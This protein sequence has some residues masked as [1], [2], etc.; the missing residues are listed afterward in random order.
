MSTYGTEF[1]H[2]DDD[3]DELYIN[4][5]CNEM[6][7]MM[8]YMGRKGI[9][10]YRDDVARL[11]AY[12]GDVLATI[13]ERP[14]PPAPSIVFETAGIVRSGRVVCFNT[15]NIDTGERK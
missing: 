14:T 2:T 7:P 3:G 13:P 6:Y 1:E 9:E 8:L 12:L 4:R 11:H 15:L 10:M 5:C